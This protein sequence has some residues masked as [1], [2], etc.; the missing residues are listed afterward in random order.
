MAFVEEL[1]LC[2]EGFFALFPKGKSIRRTFFSI[3]G[4]EA[5][6]GI[7]EKGIPCNVGFLCGEKRGRLVDMLVE[8]TDGIFSIEGQ[9]LTEERVKDYAKGVEVGT[10]VDIFGAFGLFGGDVARSTE[11]SALLGK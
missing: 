1:Y 9:F 7:F 2:K 10:P 3:F 8:D 6:E 11:V 4:K 5:L